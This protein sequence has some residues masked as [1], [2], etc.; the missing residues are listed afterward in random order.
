MAIS[1]DFESH[2]IGDGA[3]FPKPVCL[4]YYDGAETGLL[5]SE[6]SR[7][8]ISTILNK[9]LIIAHNAVFE[10]GVIV[11]HY[12]ELAERVF[13]ALDSGLVY[14]TKVNEALWN[15]QR[16]KQNNKLTL[17]ALVEHY[18]QT[19]ISAGKS[20]PDAWR[21]RY[22]EL[23]GIPISE[24]PKE[25]IDYAIDDSIWAYK[26]HNVQQDID[27]SLALKAAVYLNLMGATGFTVEKERVLLLEQE[28]WQY[29][30]PRY[31]FLVA[32][33]FCDYIPRQTQPRK[34]M[35]KLREYIES[36]EVDLQYTEKGGVA[37][38]GEALAAYLTQKDD[39]VLK[40]FS[41]LSKYEKILTSY[42]KNLKSSTGKIYSQY[43]TTKNTGRTS[44]SGS[45]LFPS[46]NIQQMPRAVEDVTY[47]VRNCFIPR[48][49]FKIC[50][51]DYSGLE[52]CS[53]AHQLYSTLGYSYMRDSLNEGDSPTDM[54]SKLAAK[55]KKVSYDD[56]VSHKKEPEYKDARQKAKPIN[57]GFPGGIG[58][59]TM[60]HLMW[61]DGIK[62]KFQVLETAK[63]KTDLY[64]YLTNLHAPDLRIR[65]TNKNEY[66]LVQDELV[67]LKRYIFDLYP[68]LE[69]FLK[70]TH[71]KFLTGKNKW[72]KN[73]FGEWEEEP[74]Y[75]YEIHGFRRDWCTY[76]ALCNGFLMQTPAAIGAQKAM[77]GIIREFH[78]NPDVIP[79]AFI[80]DEVI[81]EIREDNLEVPLKRI[82][83][84]L[85]DEM[86]TVLSSVRV[87]VEAEVCGEMWRKAGGE[88]A[89]TYWK[90]VPKGILN[91]K[92]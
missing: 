81:V 79:Q 82:S 78:D 71:N 3:V 92:D 47:D 57:L 23:D 61:R 62:T 75:A 43:S 21:L 41:E 9:E 4:S 24:W 39:A 44:S 72:V 34:Q 30:T 11:T 26:I 16:E 76:T 87:A 13:E 38:S 2:L 54:H 45:S 59:D 52:L 20:E 91:E 33:G 64:Y 35:K 63:Q 49:G 32:E 68:E 70:E 55:I 17:A 36:I 14:C 29:L 80:H 18:F 28:I 73:E 74:M 53:A 7:K 40:A 8:Y 48:P 46:V 65:R 22:S 66:A 50:S 25:A 85:I 42:I 86:Q 6:E 51:I 60:R 56:F 31:D 84:I 12:P 5:N 83:E 90:D 10:C 37:T 69:Q 58:Y 77:C 19:D 89:R 88:W 67:V 15:T 1:I 27:Q